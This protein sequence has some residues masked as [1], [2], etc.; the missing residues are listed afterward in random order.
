MTSLKQY[1]NS[2]SLYILL[3]ILYLLQGVLYEGGSIISQ[4]LLAIILLISVFFFFKVN[5]GESKLPSFLKVL[6]LFI[7]MMT[8]YGFLAIFDIDKLVTGELEVSRIEALKTLYM[9]LLPIYVMYYY[10]SR[11]VL[12][13]QTIRAISI[14]L[15]VSTIFI[16]YKSYQ[17]SLARA[18]AEGS[19][20][21]EFTNNTSYNFLQLLPLLF[22]W[23][24]KPIIQILLAATMFTFIVMG[25][26]RGAMAIGAV[27]LLWFFYQALRQTKGWSRLLVIVILCGGIYV[28]VNKLTEFYNTSDYFQQRIEQTMAGDSS[29]RDVI[30]D[31]LWSHFQS[32][33]SFVRQ[34]L[35]NG[36]YATIKIAG[37][38]AHNDWLELLICQGLLGVVVY[39]FYFLSLAKNI[40]QM[41]DNSVVYGVLI[42]TFII[43][44]ASTLFSMSYNNLELS[45]AISLGYSL[46]TLQKD[47]VH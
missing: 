36:S 45:I 11:Q 41:R 21:D 39:V 19:S 9:S 33:T 13:E 32:E 2:C 24:K 10:T 5:I 46:S 26:K 12:T 42:M 18:L 43:M 22:F 31:K 35:G 6:N 28:G 38:Y 27:C 30:F 3:W 17:E 8:I 7:V 15:I 29:G 20:N 14:V 47:A 40:Y 1:F 37:N 23:R 25:L 34:L 44:I 16:F 4:A